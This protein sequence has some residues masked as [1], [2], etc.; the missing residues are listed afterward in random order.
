MSKYVK[1]MFETTSG[2]N[3]E[4]EYK[5]NEINVCNNWNST[6][7][8]G[9]D[10]GGFNYADE[11]SIIRWLHR[12]DT[13]YDVEI[14]KDAENLKIDSAT[15]IYRT[16][17]IIIKNP[18]KVDDEL[19]LHFYKISNIPEAAYPRALGAVAVMNYKNTALK[20]IRDKI[21]RK[22]IDLYLNEWNDFIYHDGKNDRE[23]I[24][25][26]VKEVDRI[27]KEIKSDLLISINV[28]KE[29]YIKKISED[30]IINITGESGSGK[31]SYTNKYFNNDDYI[32]ID[33]DEIKDNRLTDNQNSLEF[34]RFL[35]EKYGENVLDICES[36]NV[37]Y[38]DILDYYKDTDKTLLIDSAQF[39]NLRTEEDLKLLKGK[40]IVMRTDI[41]TCYERCI[42]RFS[43]KHPNAT[44]EAKEKYANKKKKMYDWYKSLNKFIIRIDNLETSSKKEK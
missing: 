27:L 35:K 39:R 44:R 28:N 1:V 23:D 11:A 43:L 22:N 10:F 40:I 34:R 5:I 21:N 26:T 16:N 4:F 13:I 7:L 42:K 30:K 24:N 3:K 31:S 33:T 15:T 19:A 36:F 18:R 6:A 8:T 37:I 38:K 9:R 20:L 25:E 2:A 32:V 12:G 17:K 29:P 14:P 41:D